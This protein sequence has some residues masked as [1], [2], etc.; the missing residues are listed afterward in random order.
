MTSDFPFLV[1]NI[2]GHCPHDEVPELVN[3][4]ITQ[5]VVKMENNNLVYNQKE[6]GR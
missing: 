1:Y 4:I 3:S 6:V 2:S 5:W